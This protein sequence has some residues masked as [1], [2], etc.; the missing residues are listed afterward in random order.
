[1]IGNP[2]PSAISADAFILAN[3]QSVGSLNKS[4]SGT[5]YFWTHNNGS[6]DGSFQNSDYASYNLT[7]GIVNSKGVSSGHANKKA[8]EFYIA[9]GQGFLVETKANGNVTFTNEMRV[10]VNENANN[11]NFYRSSTAASTSK[12]LEKHRIWLDITDNNS[13]FNQALF[14][15]VENA[16]N[17]I[18]PIFDGSYNTSNTFGIYSLIDNEPY[19]IQA[20]ALPFNET[21]ILPLGFKTDSNGI[22]TISLNSTDGLFENGQYIYLEDKLTNVIHALNEGPYSFETQSGTYNDR[23]FIKFK[24]DNNRQARQASTLNEVSVLSKNQEMIVK[25][26]AQPIKTIMVYDH[27]GRLVYEASNIDNFETTVS[28]LVANSVYIVKT[29]LKNGESLSSKVIF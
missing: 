3:C 5:L 29:V 18:D 19:S 28:N 22:A 10:G 9:S 14:G 25:C 20:K 26:P 2:Y 16:S 11:S 27:L 7:G 8:P 4:I 17:G 1:M 21:D 24:N 23:F 13:N 6:I 12:K 15:Y